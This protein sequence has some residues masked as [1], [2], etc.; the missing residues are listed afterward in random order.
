[1][2]PIE[3]MLGRNEPQTAA[4]YEERTA[5]AV[6]AVLIEIAQILGSS[7]A[8]SSSS[9]ELFPGCFWTGHAPR[10]YWNGLCGPAT[11][12]GS[13]ADVD[14]ATEGRTTKFLLTLTRCQSLG[15]SATRG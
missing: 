7:A 5:R 14:E 12:G 9:V 1:M 4:D 3:P 10:G 2:A 13:A 8:G 6:R 11:G 15:V